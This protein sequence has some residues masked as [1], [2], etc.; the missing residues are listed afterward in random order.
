M[1]G[2]VTEHA[3]ALVISD[4]LAERVHDLLERN[5]VCLVEGWERRAAVVHGRSGWWTVRAFHDHVSCDCFAGM[6]GAV[7]SH[8]IAAMCV[9]AEP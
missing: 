6:A 8:Q 2:A 5:A 3:I 1:G 4:D 9:W 7:C